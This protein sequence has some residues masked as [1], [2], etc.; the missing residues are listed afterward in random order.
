MVE[1]HPD[2]EAASARFRVVNFAAQAI[3]I[4]LF[5]FITTADFSTFMAVREALLLRIA[6]I[7]ESSGSGL[8][9]PTEFLQIEPVGT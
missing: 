4:E 3:E 2:V 5:A 6:A 9:R 1:E 7:I 8:A